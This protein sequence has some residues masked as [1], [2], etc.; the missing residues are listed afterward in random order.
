MPVHEMLR[1]AVKKTAR[2]HALVPTPPPSHERRLLATKPGLPTSLTFG[3]SNTHPLSPPQLCHASAEQQV[4]TYEQQAIAEEH[5]DKITASI[6]ALA[7]STRD[8]IER[9]HKRAVERAKRTLGL[10]VAA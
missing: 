7:P 1:E 3:R 9:R 8:G 2:D 6:D 5:L 4:D 10:P